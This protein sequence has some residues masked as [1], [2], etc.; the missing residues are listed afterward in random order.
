MRTRFKLPLLYKPETKIE[1]KV[2]EGKTYVCNLPLWACPD[3]KRYFNTNRA[4][5]SEAKKEVEALLKQRDAQGDSNKV[6]GDA[7]LDS[8]VEKYLE[9]KSKE[10]GKKSLKKY[11]SI[12]KES[13]NK[14][15]NKYKTLYFI[16]FIVKKFGRMPTVDELTDE[17]II[18]EFLDKSCSTNATWNDKRTELYSFF[19]YSKK[20]N[21]ISTNPV[22][23]ISR[24]EET[25]VLKEKIEP[26]TKEE[27]KKVLD[28]LKHE[29]NKNRKINFY[30]QVMAVLFYA[31]LRISEATHL[32]KSDIDFESHSI[33]IRN[34]TIL[35][36]TYRTK[37]KKNWVA[38]INKDLENI[39]REWFDKTKD[40]ESEL[41]FPNKEGKPP[42]SDYVAIA[43]KKVMGILNITKYKI[44]RPLHR[45]RHTFTSFAMG[46][47]IPESDVQ[48]ALGHSSNIMTRHYTHLSDK[49]RRT[50]FDKMS[51]NKK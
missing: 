43:V 25:E 4:I 8:A 37:T 16:P 41:L 33:H 31:G 12:F 29:D 1:G 20:Q 28:Y 47:E 3:G 6:Y 18:E 51:L 32:L 10:V 2:Y 13:K 27:V 40:S 7:S 34:K 36:E 39:L 24:R 14:G 42:N 23:E 22:E 26:Y 49:Y 45:G 15:F 9:K 21:W 38:T 50:Q 30:Y 19:K 17:N 11:R 44:S 5:L 46:G 35:G 48:K